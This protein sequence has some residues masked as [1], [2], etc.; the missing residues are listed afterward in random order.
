MPR[1][2][3]L[4]ELE[5]TVLGLVWSEGPCSPYRIRRVF[6]TSPSPYWSGSAGAIYPL[7]T[8]L[9]AAG[10]LRS[11]AYATGARKGLRYRL[12]PAGLRALTAWLGSPADDVLIGV[13]PDPLR[14]RMVFLALLPPAARRDYLSGAQT[15]MRE[16]LA[17]ARRDL[18]HRRGEGP[19]AALVAE[20]A[21]AAIEARLRWLGRASTKLAELTAPDRS[22]PSRPSIRDRR[23]KS[24]ALRRGSSSGR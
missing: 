3:P 4:T 18:A 22:S 16:H 17:R 14:T 2:K 23:A 8:R 1:R 24:S 9:E 19:Y 13:P 15:R 7:M 20:G 5:G 6:T 12:T 21:I 10:F 11:K